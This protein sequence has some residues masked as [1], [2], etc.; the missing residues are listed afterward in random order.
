M[1]SAPRVHHQH[2]PDLLYLERDGLDP[3]VAADL[4]ARG[5]AL[6]EREPMCDVQAIMILPDG[7]RAGAADPRG[8]G[9]AAGH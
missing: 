8:P 2:L 9:H 6:R 3:A 1:V 5:H 4:A 7:R